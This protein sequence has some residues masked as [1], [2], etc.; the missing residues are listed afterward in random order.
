VEIF[1]IWFVLFLGA[2]I[3]IVAIV[4]LFTALAAFQEKD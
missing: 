1:V 4:I 2:A 3:A